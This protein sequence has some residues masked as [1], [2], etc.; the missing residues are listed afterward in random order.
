MYTTIAGLIAVILTGT[1]ALLALSI[2][3][4]PSMLRFLFHLR[5]PPARFYCN[6]LKAIERLEALGKEVTDKDKE[7]RFGTV[8]QGD[9][10]FGELTEVL[11]EKR[12]LQGEV[13]E[14]R[15]IEEESAFT[16]GSD[17][18]DATSHKI[19]RYL[20]LLRNGKQEPLPYNPSDPT[21]A[22]RELKYWTDEITRKR[23]GN[24]LIVLI[25][26]YMAAGIYLVIIT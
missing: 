18:F 19:V 13:Q 14:I 10:G 12:I 7:H 25:L 4:Y 3:G 8:K 9:V 15:L 24:Y 11:T 23:V 16:V 1:I 26:L 17:L 20:V 21:Q 2:G 22:T 6:A 5:F